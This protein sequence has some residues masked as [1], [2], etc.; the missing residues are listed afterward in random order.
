MRTVTLTAPAQVNGN[1]NTRTDWFTRARIWRR[2]LSQREDGCWPPI[3]SVAFALFACEPEEL[4]RVSELPRRKYPFLGRIADLFDEDADLFEDQDGEFAEIEEEEAEEEEDHD[5]RPA[6]PELHTGLALK[7]FRAWRRRAVAL[8]N[9]ALARR[10]FMRRP[11]QAPDCVL[12][13][14]A[15]PLC[16]TMPR[17]LRL[18]RKQP[19]R[20]A[21][22]Q[23]PQP[24]QPSN[25]SPPSHLSF[26]VK[27]ASLTRDLQDDEGATDRKGFA[28]DVEE[29]PLA[30]GSSLAHQLHMTTDEPPRDNLFAPSGDSNS[31]RHAAA[32]G[33]TW[34]SN[35]ASP[36]DAEEEPLDVEAVWTT[37]LVLSVLERFSE[38]VLF[39]DEND[40]EEHTV[41]DAG[42]E[43]LEAQAAKHPGLAALLEKG[44]IQRRAANLTAKWQAVLGNRVEEIRTTDAL[45]AHLSL[46]HLQRTG[47]NLTQAI[48]TRHETFS[49]FLTPGLDGLRRWQLFMIL[50]TL[51]ASQLLVNIWMFYSR[52]ATCCSEIRAL[53]GCDPTGP[54]REAMAD[55]TDLPAQFDVNT[56]FVEP[57][58]QCIAAPT[59]V[60]D[61]QCTAFPD[62]NNPIDSFLVGLISLGMAL[63]VTMFLQSLFDLSNEV[64]VA[65]IWLSWCVKTSR[66]LSSAPTGPSRTQ[67]ASRF[68][69]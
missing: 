27:L 16:L 50:F 67:L 21:S 68:F 13:A 58:S 40:V 66:V 30:R 10:G 28:P 65:D 48:M 35:A 61:Y 15:A 4:E 32:A 39:S 3:A 8:R 43:Y 37:L 69:V 36:F 29:A 22:P 25:A 38:C 56:L 19:P 64:K 6:N 63:P 17:S 5:A 31:A 23:P 52:G 47:L 42:H 18:L 59:P 26:Q 44:L 33:G 60:V 24:P 12:T 45:T 9:A 57:S 55:C 54:C 34:R 11:D 14:T 62:D 53:L 46:A 51:V 1:L 41:V 20:A 2:V 7:A 49:T